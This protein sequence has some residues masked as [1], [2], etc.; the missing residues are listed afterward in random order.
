[1]R[2]IIR[3]KGKTALFTLMIFILTLV[4]SLGVSVW[5]SLEQFLDDCDKY[6]T[7]IGLVE[8]MGTQY[9]SDTANDPALDI[10]L[11]SLDTSLIN[12]DEA[13]LHW[14]KQERAMGYVDG[15]WR[16][17]NYM[18]DSMKSVMV[19]GGLSYSER[20]HLYH[21]M[22][23][24]VLYSN[25]SNPNTI[26][27]IDGDFATF[28]PGHYYLV[29]GETYYRRSPL[30]HL[31]P[32]SYDNTLAA[33]EGIEV[34]RSIDITAHGQDGQFYKIPEDSVLTKVAETLQ[35][36]NN[37]VLVN[38]T[39]DLKS[40]LPF[41][42][43]EQYFVEGRSFSE[44][45]YA[46]GSS[47]CV[48]PSLMAARMGIT[49]GDTID[50]SVSVSD[51]PGIYNSYWVSN[52]FSSRGKFEVVGITN[53]VMDKSWYIY[54]PKSSQVPSSPFPIGYT[55]GQAV[56]RNEQADSFYSR[57]ETELPDR[58]HLTV[59]DQGYSAV[60]K[61][62][63][64]MLSVAK[65]VTVVCALMEL[66]V[67]ILFGFLFVFRQKETSETMQLLG[68]GR[69]R[70]IGYFLFSAG[71]ISLVATG[72]GAAT[73]YGLH[74]AII[75]VVGMIARR[76]TLIDNRYSNGN[77][78]SLRTLAFSPHVQWEVF[79][80]IGLIVFALALLTCLGFSVGTFPGR[81]RNLRKAS[82]PTKQY[83]TSRLGGGTMK[84]AILSALR[85]GPRSLVVPIFAITA[86]IFFGQL[87]RTSVQYQDQLNHIFD[88]IKV[89]GYYTDING[90]QIGHQVLNAYDVANLYHTGLVDA[91]NVSKSKPFYYLG[92]S[93][94][95]DG[96]SQDIPPLFMP[97][98]YF[99]YE[100]LEAEIQRGPDLTAAND[101]ATSPEFFYTDTI[102]THF[103]NGYDETFLTAPSGETGALVCLVPTSFMEDK[104]I[105]IGDTIRLA[106]DDVYYSSEYHA[107]I[108]RHYDLLVVGSYEKQGVE[109]TIY[110]PLSVFFDTSLI[111]G[112]GQETT[113]APV[114]TFSLGYQIAEQQKQ[115]LLSNTLNSV[116]FG[117]GNS[118]D[119][120]AFKDYLT[121]YGYSQVKRVGSVREFIVLNDALLNNTVASIRQQIIY[122]N[123]LYPCLYVLVGIAALITSYLLVVGRKNEVATMRGLGTSGRRTFFSF[124]LEQ[125]FLCIIGT[126][127]GVILWLL[128]GGISSGLHLYLVAGFL[129]CFL[130]GSAIS[131]TIM[132]RS[133]VFSILSDRD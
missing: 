13:I 52:G 65:I 45:E 74:D 67:L 111:W 42:Q 19:V 49:I 10:G 95:A 50:L 1:M 36:T 46:Q 130:L 17:D 112:P 16:S 37:S 60:A 92:V 21:G 32:T 12:G 72:A 70:V 28:E 88:T 101:L 119:L 97:L 79:L 81:K 90:K 64:T 108:F 115:L 8:F 2:S 54:I 116:S 75:A 61:P 27:L 66:S 11:A 110:L 80:V 94:K 53:T 121:E 129:G 107:S 43:E 99:A 98:S 30:L 126:A 122:I 76:L 82:G 59:Y 91:I 84:F 55:V 4:L 83:K 85:G 78:S 62:F 102:L 26:V 34:P 44:E 73:G 120:I 25:F 57:I 71:I 63:Q 113:G 131:V 104:G 9:P 33:S 29:F 48:I 96:T 22:V 86:I 118:N 24:Q 41:Q 20:D 114:E 125:G 69:M 109:D 124:F 6:F 40:L 106:I 39:S 7:T 128:F 31:H 127:G 14:E 35:V 47:V 56:I 132:I 105:Q 68:T 117:L 58:F 38:E 133:N 87:A 5:R 3:S 93:R 89:D 18:P 51:M 23:T 123:T 103:I 15:F 77:L 100:S